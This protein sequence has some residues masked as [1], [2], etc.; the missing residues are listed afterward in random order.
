MKELRLNK[1]EKKLIDLAEQNGFEQWSYK[2]WRRN[3]EGMKESLTKSMVNNGEWAL[4]KEYENGT[5]I[6]ITTT[7]L[8]DI[9]YYVIF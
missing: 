2:S 9:S 5:R 6:K 4:V 1:E 8:D 3:T 7:D